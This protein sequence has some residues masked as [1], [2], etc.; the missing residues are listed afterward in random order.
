[1]RHN[2]TPCLGRLTCMTPHNVLARCSVSIGVAAGPQDFAGRMALNNSKAA[3]SV[4]SVSVRTRPAFKHSLRLLQLCRVSRPPLF[5]VSC[6][7]L[8]FDG[9]TPY[10]AC[11]LN[12][13]LIMYPAIL[14]ICRSSKSLITRIDDPRRVTARTIY[15]KLE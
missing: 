4:L 8:V 7:R 5:R 2:M 3:M 10:A 1:M 14:I 11:Q 15:R 12:A 9:R 13:L 6:R